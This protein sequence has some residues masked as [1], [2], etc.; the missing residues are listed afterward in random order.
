MPALEVC[1]RTD[2]LSVIALTVD[3]PTPAPASLRISFAGAGRR[4]G[5]S[6]L[7]LVARAT[8]ED[9]IAGA[10][11]I[12]QL[13]DG[14]DEHASPGYAP[15]TLASAATILRRL[16]ALQERKGSFLPV[17]K[18]LPGIDGRIELRWRGLGWRLL[19]QVHPDGSATFYGESS[20]RPVRGALPADEQVLLD[21]VDAAVS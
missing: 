5:G 17:P 18:I 13:E 9:E 10:A 15:E 16:A 2:A 6:V 8:L 14:W 4:T 1:G 20:G 21:W 19:M 11:W 12:V 7:S 3:V